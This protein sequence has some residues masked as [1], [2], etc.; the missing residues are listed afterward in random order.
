M[1]LIFRIIFY[2]SLADLIFLIIYTKN[3]N[4]NEVVIYLALSLILIA[5]IIIIILMIYNY[6]RELDDEKTIDDFILEGMK[7]YIDTLNE[8][9]VNIASFKYNHY[10]LEIEC[11]LI[12]KSH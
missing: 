1:D 6:I 4:F 7:N 3:A 9:Y 10:K 5:C 12:E 2:F 11:T 8:I